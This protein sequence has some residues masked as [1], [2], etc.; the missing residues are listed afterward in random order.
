MKQGEIWYADINP[1]RGSEQAG[2]RPVAILSGNLMNRYLNLVII[3]PLTSKIKNYKGNP[4]LK[5]SPTNGLKQ[6]SEILIFQLRSVSKEHL[7]EKVGELTKVELSQALET[8]NDLT[9]L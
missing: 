5:P 1:V 3:A 9:T 6:D 2:Y 8:L 4:I 7:I